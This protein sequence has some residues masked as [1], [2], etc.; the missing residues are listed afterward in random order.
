MPI[1]TPNKEKES[2]FVSRCMGDNVMVKEYPDQKQR[3]AICY[4]QYKKAKK[5]QKAK[6]C[7]DEPIWEE[8]SLDKVI[9]LY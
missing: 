6:G 4:S 1:P 7:L 9:M 2:N 3:A 5:H 8:Q